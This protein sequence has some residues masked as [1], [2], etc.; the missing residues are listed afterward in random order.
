MNIYNKPP[1][2]ITEKAADYLAKIV[3]TV[4]RL[5]FG[6]FFKRDIK[7]HRENRVRTIHSSL[8]I[9]G[10]SLSLDEVTA[11]IEG[12][13]V[14]GKQAEMKEV[15]NAYE[16]YDKIMTFD[17]YSVSDFL[18]AH[19]LMTQ[20]LVKESGKFRSGDV[21]VFDGVVVVHVGERPQFVLQLI[22]DLF[23]WAKESELHL[24]LKSAI[25]HYEIE[26]IH[27][28]AD[29]NGRIGRLWQTLLLAKWNPIFAW[30]PMESVLYQN[31][32]QYYQAIQDAKK[33]NDSGMFI[34]FTLS[35]LF[36]IIA[37][38]Q[39]HQVEHEH[40]HQVDLSDFA[41]SV[42]KT[43]G[44]KTLSRKEIF[45]AIGMNGDSRSFKR[46]IEP[47]ITGGFIKMTV[48]E[49]PNSKLQKYRL[50]DKGTA[51]IRNSAR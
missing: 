28:F 51:A 39:K 29:G 25:L 31:R 35:A 3:E 2:T 7:L 46:N 38:Q 37:Q 45:A 18:K 42:L 17:P 41:I 47:L 36:E 24:I 20:G 40:K 43:I 22:E 50:T 1:Y 34:E 32:P 9:E 33:A 10:N 27:P 44:G 16:A 5:E 4:T 49:K 6:T 23:G 21:G 11:V 8:A 19:K 30:I 48:P 12:K 15:K 13:V 14:A 26:T